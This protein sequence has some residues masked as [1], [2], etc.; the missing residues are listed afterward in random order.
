M[1]SVDG[2]ESKPRTISRWTFECL[3]LVTI[4]LLT[5]TE[6]IAV[7]VVGRCAPAPH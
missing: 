3:V 4:V 6:M 1:T 2:M 5:V 7:L